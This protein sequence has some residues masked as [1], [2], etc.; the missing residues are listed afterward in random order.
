MTTAA[1]YG[2][3][4]LSTPGHLRITGSVRHVQDDKG[5]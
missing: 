2:D 1:A 3:K 4:G 5:K